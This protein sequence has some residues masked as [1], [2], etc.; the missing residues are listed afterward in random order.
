MP[1]LLRLN[2]EK[3]KKTNIVFRRYHFPEVLAWHLLKTVLASWRNTFDKRTKFLHSMFE[4]VQKS[5]VFKKIFP[6]VYYGLLKSLYYDANEKILTK[7]KTNFYHCS[8]VKKQHFSWF[9]SRAGHFGGLD[10]TFRNTTKNLRLK[11]QYF[12]LIVR[13]WLR[14]VVPGEYLS[15]KSY[16]W[17]SRRKFWQLLRI[18]RQK[19]RILPLNFRKSLRSTFLQNFFLYN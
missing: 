3:D 17:T 1:G 18:L 8:K 5:N 12:T 6:D 14:S 13:Y 11:P 2:F 10:Y 15:A 9:F 4:K 16:L 7:S 19:A